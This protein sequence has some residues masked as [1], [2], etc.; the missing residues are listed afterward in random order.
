MLR[1]T[2]HMK[3]D[4]LRK[5]RQ[6]LARQQAAELRACRAKWRRRISAVD[7][8]GQGAHTAKGRTARPKPRRPFR[9]AAFANALHTAVNGERQALIMDVVR[10]VLHHRRGFF[11]AETLAAFLNTH[12]RFS[13]TEQQISPPLGRLCELGEIKVVEKGGYAERPLYST[14]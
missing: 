10:R 2:L 3:S 4:W 7:R 11:T 1:S 12:H 14:P 9:F 5:R 13:F 6:Q 8:L